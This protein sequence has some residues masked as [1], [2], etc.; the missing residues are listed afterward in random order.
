[1]STLRLVL[2]L[3]CPT[4]NFPLIPILF[5]ALLPVLT[6]AQVD[7]TDGLVGHYPFDGNAEDAIGSNHGSI[8]GAQLTTDRFGNPDAAYQFDGI[9]DRIECQSINLGTQMSISI[10]INISQ[11][12]NYGDPLGAQNQWT[13]TTYADGHTWSAVGNG[14]TPRYISS[15]GFFS[16]NL[17][18]HLVMTL[19]NG[20]LKLYKDGVLAGQGTGPAVTLNS[21]FHIGARKYPDTD[22]LI[23][24]F[25]GKVDDIRFYNRPINSSE[26]TAIFQDSPPPPGPLGADQDWVF[27]ADETEADPIYRTGN[28]AIG[29]NDASESTL[30]IKGATTTIA[31]KS[32]SIRNAQGGPTLISHDNGRTLVALEESS[33]YGGFLN[34]LDR[35]TIVGGS[36]KADLALQAPN[37]VWGTVGMYND[38]M[39][40]QSQRNI[41][42]G[43]LTDQNALV[44][45]Q[46]GSVGLGTVNTE[47][48]RL[49]VDGTI[50][51]REVTVTQEG[52]AD[53]VFAD[54]YPLMDISALSE[55]VKQH[56][57]LPNVPSSEEVAQNG[58][59]LGETN[60]VLLEKIEELTLYLIR[61]NKKIF[62]LE[63]RLSK[64]E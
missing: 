42:L 60:K 30:N 27:S 44:V 53:Y 3:A 49:A 36:T 14:W 35:A 55:Y 33:V 21:S 51:T 59:A 10:W 11:L 47:T 43:H 62:E 12:K 46:N 50:K 58:L 6:V 25:S 18:T 45:L 39:L 48:H 38:K 17:W 28:V 34:V 54:D 2:G 23:Y 5:M 24:P 40:I 63:K 56:K 13:F 4:S 15:A 26:V 61:Q 52:W 64:L 31:G 1:M 32:L 20:T 9:D 41:H 57:H 22:G 37:D 19:D 16:E 8:V 29:T 7:I